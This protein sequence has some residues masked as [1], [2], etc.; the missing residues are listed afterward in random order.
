MI[1]SSDPSAVS[2]P[3]LT[4]LELKLEP[5][6]DESELNLLVLD[7]LDGILRPFDAKNEHFS[8][9]KQIFSGFCNEYMHIGSLNL[10]IKTNI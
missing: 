7:E 8:H 4:E 3:E 1:T 10:T 9:Y 5:K 6:L 2:I